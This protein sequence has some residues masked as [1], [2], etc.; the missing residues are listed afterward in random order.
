MYEMDLDVDSLLFSHVGEGNWRIARQDRPV[1]LIDRP[2]GIGKLDNPPTPVFSARPWP[3]TTAALVPIEGEYYRL[4]IGH[5][6]VLDTPEL[7]NVQMHYFHFRPEVGMEA[8]MD[9]WLALGG[10]H[11]F[12]TNLGAHASAWRRLADL[13]ARVGV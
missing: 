12:V 4:V 13:L 3:A 8:F 2:W 7:P 5:G 1:P 11:H 9:Q 10:P 6:E